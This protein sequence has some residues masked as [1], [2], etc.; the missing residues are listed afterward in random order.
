M[1][2]AEEM[3]KETMDGDDL[4]TAFSN[5]HPQYL[6]K[7]SIE[8]IKQAQTEAIEET[9]KACAEAAKSVCCCGLCE[10][11]ELIHED[12]YVYCS[13]CE[14]EADLVIRVSK[15]SILEVETQLK[16]L[17]ILLKTC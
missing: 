17:D 15:Q 13:I 2:K 7:K 1:R 4:Y 9:V 3:L 11:E 16:A 12:G 10:N 6:L 14:S 5:W 8:A